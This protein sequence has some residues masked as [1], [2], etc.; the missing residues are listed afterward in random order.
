MNT[1][2]ILLV[3]L[4]CPLTMGAMMF[5]MMRGRRGQRSQAKPH[6]EQAAPPERADNQAA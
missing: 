5:L 4:V 6:P 1:L 3:A 2:T